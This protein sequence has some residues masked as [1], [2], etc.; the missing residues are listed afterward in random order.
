MRPTMHHPLV[1]LTYLMAVDSQDRV[2]QAVDQDGA[3]Y[4][5]AYNDTVLDLLEMDS[6][7]SHGVGR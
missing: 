7:D 2:F 5:T 6:R 1:S 4:I 3:L